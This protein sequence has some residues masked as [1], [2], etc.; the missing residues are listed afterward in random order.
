MYENKYKININCNKYS[1][2]IVKNDYGNIICWM[3]YKKLVDKIKSIENVLSWMSKSAAFPQQVTDFCLPILLADKIG[4]QF[5]LS[6]ISLSLYFKV[7]TTTVC[8]WTLPH[9]LQSPIF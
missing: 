5:G 1:S 8:S 4:Q 2:F 9:G 3:I 6:D 7:Q